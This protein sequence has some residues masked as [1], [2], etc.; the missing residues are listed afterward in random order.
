VWLGFF[1]TEIQRLPRSGMW[2]VWVKKIFGMILLGMPLY[3]LNAVMPPH[4]NQ[5]LTPAY[6]V[7]SGVLLGFVFSGKGV[8]PGFKKFQIAFGIFLIAMGLLVYRA[9]PQPVELNFAA[10]QDSLIQQAKKEGKPV[11]I[12]FS[13]N[14]CL[15]CKELEIKTFPDIRVREELKNWVLLKADLTQ[16][17]SGPVEELKKHYGIQGVP[18]LIFLG[19][20]GNERKDLRAVGFI[21]SDEM[22]AKLQKAAA[23]AQ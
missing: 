16:Y 14:W 21:T 19:A 22:I 20:D 9:W 11:F 6:L 12:D 4:W 15:P 5:V 8:M 23:K 2:M 17:S 1:S 7:L 10:Y 3:F 13:A 18:T